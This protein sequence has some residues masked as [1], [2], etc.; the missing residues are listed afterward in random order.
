MMRVEVLLE[1]PSAEAFLQTVFPL[2]LP[3]PVTWNPIVFQGKPDLLKNLESR[4]KAY[5]HWIPNDW[6]IVVLVDEDRQDC[7]ALKQRMEVAAANAMLPTKTN[8]NQGNFVV[9]NRI[10]VEELEAWF[11]GD[12]QALSEAYPGVSPNLGAKA[13]FRN[14]DAILGGTWESLQRVLQNAGYYEGGLPKTEVAREVSRRMQPGRNT[15]RSFQNFV[16][17]LAAL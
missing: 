13:R 8:P 1:E 17:A 5:R 3:P 9:V 15:S 7:R 2:L 16:S 14:P 12:P 4:L 10:A 6:R 11:F